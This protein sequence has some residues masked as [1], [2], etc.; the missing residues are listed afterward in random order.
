MIR[1]V[2]IFA[3]AALNVVPAAAQDAPG[4]KVNTVIIYGDDRCPE[5]PGDTITVCARLPEGERYRIPP[6][7]RGSDSPANE[8]W[9][10]KVIAYERVGKSGTMSCSPAGA[11]GWTGCAGQLIDKAYAEKKEDPSVR[12]AE[13][14]EAERAKRLQTI[15]A[16]AAETQKRVEELERQS[17]ARRA[18]R[19]N[20]APPTK[21]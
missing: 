8:A 14:I 5:A 10:N 9:S 11:G 21:P 18:E 17:D 2:P 19:E 20:T 12:F 7:L 13:L 4:E 3:L 16:E 15:D 6:S 1:L